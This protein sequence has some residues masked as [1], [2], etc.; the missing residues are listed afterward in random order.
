MR[1]E[2]GRLGGISLDFAGIPLKRDEH[3]RNEHAQRGQPERVVRTFGTFETF[4]IGT[5]AQHK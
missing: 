2:P 3:F 1:S 4:N 5:L